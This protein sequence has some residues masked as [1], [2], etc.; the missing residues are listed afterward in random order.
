MK[1]I[2][3]GN[4]APGTDASALETLFEQYGHVS[5]AGIVCNRDTGQPRGFGFVLM[6]NDR[7]GDNAIKHLN[8]SNLNGQNIHV[9]DASPP[10]A[11][12]NVKATPDRLHNALD[13]FRAY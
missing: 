13:R 4:L 2:Y 12:R 11:N 9:L 10:E 7:M 5:K 3:V 1:K 6:R 8:G